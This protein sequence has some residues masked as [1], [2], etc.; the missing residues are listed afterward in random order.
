MSDSVQPYGLQTSRILCPWG[1]PGKNTGVGCQALLQGIFPTQGSNSCLLGLLHWQE[2][3]FTTSATCE[4]D[5]KF[6]PWGALWHTLN[7]Q[8]VSTLLTRRNMQKRKQYFTDYHRIPFCLWTWKA[9]LSYKVE[10]CLRIIG[11]LQT[12]IG[13]YSVQFSRSIVSDSLRPHESQH[14]RPPCLSPTPGVYSNPCPSS[15]WCHPSISSSVVPFSSCPQSL[16]ASGLSPMSQLFAWGGQ[17][18]GVSAS[19]SVLPVNTHDWSPLGWTGWISLQ[20]KGLSRVFSNT[21]V[22]KHQFFSAQLSL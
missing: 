14:A 5:S 22:Q 6:H 7:H 2:G 11:F 18:T 12:H 1:S 15:W 10:P 16:P 17:S 20:S 3:F 4:G 8:K 13:Y 9:I 19:A 21:T